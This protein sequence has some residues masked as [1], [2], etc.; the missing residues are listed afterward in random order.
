VSGIK[1]NRLLCGFGEKSGGG[2]QPLWERVS[3]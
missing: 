1:L 2:G 3:G